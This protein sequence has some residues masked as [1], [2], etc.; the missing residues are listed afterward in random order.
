LRCT[1]VSRRF[2][3]ARGEGGKAVSLPNQV[4]EGPVLPLPLGKVRALSFNEDH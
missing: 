2:L 4:T 3:L 1:R